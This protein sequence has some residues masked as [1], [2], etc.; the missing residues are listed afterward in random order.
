MER[1]RLADIPDVTQ[2]RKA[3]RVIALRQ[4]LAG[5]FVVTLRVLAEN[6][7]GVHGQWTVE[8]NGDGADTVGVH[9]LVK[10]HHQ[11][12]RTSH[13]EARDNNFPATP[14]G[15]IHH[16]GQFLGDVRARAMEPVSVGALHDQIVHRI[17]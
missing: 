16:V 7:G 9:Q 17:G 2:E 11:L 14:R 5:F 12:L 10:H 4:K 13:G 3:E 6:L 15:A 8:K 1:L